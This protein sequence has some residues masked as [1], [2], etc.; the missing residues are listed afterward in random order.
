MRRD[1][2]VATD[3]YKVVCHDCGFTCACST[4]YS[5]IESAKDHIEKETDGSYEQPNTHHQVR[6]SHQIYVEL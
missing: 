3:T 4:P 5:A 1:D 2:L 6:I